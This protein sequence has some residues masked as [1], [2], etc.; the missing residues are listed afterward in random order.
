ASGRRRSQSR[1]DAARSLPSVGRIPEPAAHCPRHTTKPSRE[2]SRAEPSRCRRGLAAM[3]G[4]GRRSH[5]ASRQPGRQRATVRRACWSTLR[6][7]RSS[8]AGSW[9][10]AA[11]RRRR[12]LTG[13]KRRVAGS[14]VGS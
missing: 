1:T 7:R 12:R 13:G 6:V 11:A 14:A 3:G 8:A 5:A 10:G 2:P 4:T 9:V